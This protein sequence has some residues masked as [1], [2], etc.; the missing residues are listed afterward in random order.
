DVVSVLPGRAAECLRL[1]ALLA[2]ARNGSSSALVL[3]GEPGIGKTALL[4]YAREQAVGFRVLA[5]P[6]VES[7]AEIAFAALADL[8]RPILGG[9]PSIAEPQA[10]AL[11]GALALGPP[12]AADRFAHCAA[13][14][15][16]LA[17]AAEDAP[18]LALVDDLHWIDPSSAEA[19]LFAGRRLESEG[20]VL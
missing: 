18:V 15:S 12:V 9:L 2:A 1:D 8:V 4:G 5:A 13:T 6:G 20:L 16:L 3:R 14:L 19:I 7:E 11:A 10:A 17:A